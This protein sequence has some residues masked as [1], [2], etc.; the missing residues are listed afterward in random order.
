MSSNTNKKINLSVIG[1]GNIAQ[2][3][4]PAMKDAGFNVVAVAGSL[5]SKSV[6]IFAEKHNIKKV[7]NNPLDLISNISEWDAL[8][9]LSPVSTII[10]YLER[11][12]PYG[13]PIL[14]EKPV[15]LDHTL[16]EHLI[17]YNN[18]RVA[19]NRRFYSGVSFA[20]KH[21]EKCL[22]PLIKVII[23]EG[24]V[25][26]DHNVDFPDRMP[27]LTYENSVH[28]FDTLNYISGNI[29]WKAVSNIKGHDKYIGVAAL[30]N[31]VNGATVQLD[32][33]FNT[34]DNFSIS[35]VSENERLEMRPIEV[36][37]LY[38]GMEVNEPTENMPIRIYSP[39]KIKGIIDSTV[40]GYKP[41]FLGQ[42]KDFMK[43]CTGDE[44][45]YGADIYDAYLALK[46]AHSLIE[47]SV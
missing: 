47:E 4:I 35:I 42:A 10:Q 46:L 20:K 32:S 15:A 9:I 38:Q 13:K 43:Y 22:N 3:H 30:G 17:K 45:C 18:I 27:L 16:L 41:G 40:N 25:D 31:S 5:N 34:P 7:Y 14:T 21:V 2:F 44:H 11:A 39:I 6:H 36:T 24:R 26:P 37:S 28:I 29:S 12:A 23:P 8:L 1:C 33:Y 19:Y